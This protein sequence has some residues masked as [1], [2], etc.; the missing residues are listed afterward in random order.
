MLIHGLQMIQNV[1]LE[2]ILQHV[3]SSKQV[4]DDSKVVPCTTW[5][6][7]SVHTTGALCGVGSFLQLRQ[8]GLT[9]FGTA[10]C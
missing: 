4:T 6:L 5:A 3:V 9:R 2:Y 7:L 8:L 1:W 10:I